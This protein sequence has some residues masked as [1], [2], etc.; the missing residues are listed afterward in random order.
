MAPG[1]ATLSGRSLC[2]PTLSPEGT[3]AMPVLE[4]YSPCPCGSG[5]KFKWCCHKVEPYAERAHRLFESGQNSSALATLD[6]GLRKEPGNAWLLT[7]KAIYS[8]RM[9]QV[10]QA[11]ESV[12]KILEKNPRHVSALILMTRLVLESEGAG[13]G[14]SQL[15]RALTSVPLARRKELVNLI[16]VVGTFLADTL[17]YFAALKHLRLALSLAD[18]P[19]ERSIRSSVRILESNPQISPWQKNPDSLLPP[20]E[21]VSNSVRDRFSQAL[22]WAEEGLWSS[23]ASAFETLTSDPLAGPTASRN[24]GLCRLWLADHAAAVPALRRYVASQGATPESVDI[25]ALCQQVALPEGDDLVEHVQLSWP[26][27]N[28]QALLDALMADDSIV[29]EESGPLDPEDAQSELVDQ[30]ALLDRPAV[31]TAE[32]SIKVTDIP[33]IVSRVFVGKEFVTLETYDDGRLDPIVV[34]FTS[35]VNTAIPPAHPRTKVLSKVPRLQLAL[36]WEWILPEGIDNALEQRISREQRIHLLREVWANTSNPALGNKTPLLASQTRNFEIPLR[37]A[38]LLLELSHEMRDDDFEATGL[39][40]LLQLRPEPLLDPE[41]VDIA[42]LHLA[43]L[44]MVPVERLNDEKLLEFYL[45]ARQSALSTLLARAAKVLVDRPEALE[46]LSIGS[47]AV[48]TDLASAAASAH[49]EEE[50]FEWVRR[51]RQ[52]D[53]IAKRARN[54]P[55]WDLY[56]VRLK[57][58]FSTPETWV[59]E[60][61]IVLDRYSTNSGANQTVMMELIDMGLLQ[62]QPNPDRDGEI[63]LDSRPLQALLAEYGPRVTTSS[64]QLGISATRSEIWTPGSGPETAS[65]GLWT[66][67]SS[68]APQRQETEKKLI[69]PG[70]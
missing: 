1:F 57:A 17:E 20:P 40:A 9:G 34:R 48:Y 27:R 7:R 58:I 12:R 8:I 61:A 51:G 26:V 15:Q 33:R 4:P 30:F 13:A 38:V 55:A 68:S 18:A 67:G 49:R 14:A 36:M 46:R 42:S 56:E 5:E 39:R 43:R 25:E 44:A 60:L 64:G 28:R 6:E 2:T 45:R 11:R 16:V 19:S 59:P 24:L 63:L 10:D 70:R 52:A 37:A 41:T 35:L 66:P 62:I 32:P 69:V 47:I 21:S 65:K 23:A 31:K 53:P 3:Q 22:N 50:A 29:T 54:A